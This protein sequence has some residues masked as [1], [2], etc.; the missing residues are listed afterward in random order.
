MPPL[1]AGLGVPGMANVLGLPGASRVFLLLVGCL[2]W[3]LLQ[4]YEAETPFLSALA[5]DREPIISGFPATTATSIAA[6]GTSVPS[7]EHGTVGYTFAVGAG[8][9]LNALRWQRQGQ[10]PP[11]DLRVRIVPEQVQPRRTVFERAIDAGVQVRL[12]APHAQ[13]GSGCT[14]AVLRDGRFCGV[15][16]LGDLASHAQDALHGH[17]RVFCYAYDD[18]LGRLCHI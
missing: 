4:L 13:D 17:D 2:G 8:A 12:V 11:A 7:G 14:R 16:A 1:L 18:D 5:A 10:G 6:L 15:Q 9:L 3:R